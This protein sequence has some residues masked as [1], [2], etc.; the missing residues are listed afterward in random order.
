MIVFSTS[1]KADPF[2]IK[3]IY[4]YVVILYSY[5]YV[6]FIIVIQQYEIS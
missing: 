3:L 5:R 6:D 2:I 1:L 4:V